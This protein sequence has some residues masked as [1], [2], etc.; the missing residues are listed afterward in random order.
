MGVTSNQTDK[1]SNFFE[2]PEDVLAKIK[3]A[4]D[5]AEV[6]SVIENMGK[7]WQGNWSRKRSEEAKEVQELRNQVAG[8][9]AVKEK[10]EA[11]DKL[12]AAPDFTTFLQN[13]GNQ[14]NQNN[15][16]SQGVTNST[17]N[18]E[19]LFDDFE[20]APAIEKMINVI[21]EEVNKNLQATINPLMQNMVQDRESADI[22]SVKS[23][24]E[25]QR[26]AGMNLPD[27][28][29]NT[30]KMNMRKYNMGAMDAYKLSTSTFL[31]SNPS[32]SL[33]DQNNSELSDML[34]N[35]QQGNNQQGNNQQGNNQQG[36]NQQ[37]NNQQGNN[38]QT[39]SQ[40]ML[41]P[42]GAALTALSMKTNHG[43]VDDKLSAANALSGKDVTPKRTADHIQD[44]VQL[45][46]EVMGTSVSTSDL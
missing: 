15:Q 21:T 32:K 18:V 43:S 37:G 46:N 4:P 30:L 44:S 42:G 41:K 20:D 1:Q 31:M 3:A 38:Q 25:Q 5:G 45:M 11:L 29:P 27:V 36:N 35:N 28:D 12:L 10:A 2:I 9:D 34:G 8:L 6:L 19:G 26:T 14:N 22:D 33:M 23:Y 13:R 39:S 40:A 16:N 17:N 24:V 7:T